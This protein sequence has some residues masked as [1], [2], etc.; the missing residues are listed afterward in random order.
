MAISRVFRV[1]N[2]NPEVDVEWACEREK[3]F[4]ILPLVNH[5]RHQQLLISRISKSFKYRI[6]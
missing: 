5:A 6:L 3:A 4:Q 2:P 1:P